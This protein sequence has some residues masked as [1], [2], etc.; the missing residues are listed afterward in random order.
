MSTFISR[1]AGEVNSAPEALHEQL[2]L[3]PNRR[4]A[5]FILEELRKDLEEFELFP[6]F[7]TV[8]EFIA[9][10]A[11]LLV[12]EPM[13]LLVA[14][15]EC[16]GEVR[17]TSFP[18]KEEEDLG[19]FMGWGQTLLSDFSEIDRYV[20]NPEHVLGDLYNVQKL[21]EWNL[22]PE[23][24]TKM[25]RN[26]SDFIQ[27]LPQTY[28]RFTKGLLE[29]GEA[30][31]G[32]A[33]RT[34]AEQP[35]LLEAFLSRNGV[36]K[37]VVAGLNAL[38]TAE[39]EI[40]K[41]L[42]NSRPTSFLW[43]TDAHYVQTSMH[44][45]GHFL[46][47][48]QKREKVFG[49]YIP[50]TDPTQSD[51]RNL[52]KTIQPVGA[53]KFTGQAK[54][55]AKTLAQ[56]HERGIPP[57]QIAVILADESLLNPVLN[58]LPAPY[59]KVNITM[60]FPLN[61]TALAATV[62]LYLN[63]VEY[64]V[65]NQRPGK[66]WTLHHKSLSA[67][68]TDPMFNRYWT[69]EDE[70]PYAWHQEIVARN[71]VFTTAKYWGDKASEH[72]PAYGRL[73]L[74][75][76]PT[77]FIDAL[78][79][80]LEHVGATEKNNTMVQNTAHHIYTLLEQL[81]RTLQ[82]TAQDPLIWIKLIKQQLRNGSIDF[83]GEPL[84]GLQVMGILESRTL[85]FPYVILAGINEGVLP[86][87]RSFNS[88]LPF[89]IKRHYGLPTYEE[90]DAVYAYH[91]YRILQRCKEAAITFNTDKEAMGGGEP[92]RFLVQIE[93]E[94]KGTAAKV[95]PRL[96][97]NGEIQAQSVASKFEAEKTG[98]VKAAIA[99]W[100]ERGI[101]ASSLN[102]LVSMP[103]QFYKKRLIK[104]K[105]E[106]EVEENMSAMV[107]GNLVHKGL[108]K[109]YEPFVGQQIPAFDVD[110]WTE[111]AMDF[112]ITYLVEEKGYSRRALHTGRNILT[113]E[114]CRQMMR[115]FLE[116]DLHRARMH[117]IILLGIETELSHSMNHPTLGLPMNFKGYIDRIEL[118]D[119]RLT[120]WDYKTGSFTS[121]DLS[122]GAI[123]DLWKGTK[124][125]PLQV[126]LYSWLLDKMGAFPHPLPWRS[127]M[128]KLQSGA[129]EILLGGAVVNKTK[130][131]ST[132]VFQVFESALM[133][134]LEEVYTDDLPFVE[135]PKFEFK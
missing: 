25:M 123:E 47:L 113:V 132:E 10:A 46:R 67:L 8:D 76:H 16:Y 81:K 13:A 119:Q 33:A 1:I 42:R 77:D 19:Q 103:D 23:E 115:Q 58:F 28:E 2:V 7:L 5:L 38:N 84:E 108:E 87:G 104:I 56:W 37:V 18:G 49:N 111:Q 53:T 121:S 15:H 74:P 9:Q 40:L 130:D 93:H 52:P 70:G 36:K 29:R 122:L 109:V 97:S 62:G 30:Y 31:G 133:E 66:D 100:W 92:S 116:Y 61:Q 118:V 106:D 73:F 34:L 102:E 112:G 27:L 127:G 24:Q 114:V 60:G 89:D 20:L 79:H 94:L 110:L 78:Q 22:E 86:A 44:E 35:Q 59:D 69:A 72:L 129:P 43:D 126:L 99:Q 45:A 63:M 80:W 65:K 135:I 32:L 117:E 21:A 57:R 105:E 4:A 131:I 51:W 41:T 98:A 95:L 96:F 88:L 68:C 90:K 11:N 85:D 14:L 83:V 17:R 101:S 55:V 64:A 107:M 39:L 120:I 6:L 91:F 124:G 71:K 125:K 3:I 82:N 48:H 54:A 75:Q 26:Y 134:Y 128:F 50:K 12:M